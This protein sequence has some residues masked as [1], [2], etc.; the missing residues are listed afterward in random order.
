MP[1]FQRK[2][3]DWLDQQ[4]NR[5]CSE[6]VVLETADGEVSI[7]MAVIEPE[8][9]TTQQG[10]KSTTDKYVFLVPTSLLSGIDIKRGIRFKWNGRTFESVLD[11]SGRDINDPFKNRTAISAKELKL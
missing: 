4:V 9:V 6:S 5:H 10:I 1:S 3:I 2:G 8:T 7:R 11:P